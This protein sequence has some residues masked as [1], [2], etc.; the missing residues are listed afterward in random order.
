MS[1]FSDKKVDHKREVTVVGE[2]MFADMLTVFFP[3][4]FTLRLKP[5]FCLSRRVRREIPRVVRMKGL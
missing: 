2:A 4:M 1:P 5:P 3:K